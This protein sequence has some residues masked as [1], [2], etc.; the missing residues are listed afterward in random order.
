[1][2]N[3][4][5]RYCLTFINYWTNYEGTINGA[6]NR[7]LGEA[8]YNPISRVPPSD[9]VSQICDALAS[10]ETLREIGIPTN[11]AI[12]PEEKIR[13][14]LTQLIDWIEF[15]ELSGVPK[16]Q[17]IS[18]LNDRLEDLRSFVQPLAETYTLPEAV[19]TFEEKV[20]PD[21]DDV[22]ARIDALVLIRYVLRFETSKILPVLF[23]PE[24]T[25]ATFREYLRNIAWKIEDAKRR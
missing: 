12:W 6:I 4:D 25:D 2:L 9:R 14:L 16:F 15:Y 1:M 3:D 19:K 5:V 24:V 21:L 8:I 20:L 23:T 13:E 18:D 11:A 17:D 7:I 10:D 22:N